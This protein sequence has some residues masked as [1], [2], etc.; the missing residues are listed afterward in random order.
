MKKHGLLIFLFILDILLIFGFTPSLRSMGVMSVYSLME[1]H[2]SVFKTADIDIQIPGGTY[3]S[4]KDW[5]PFV[6]TY[7][8]DGFSRYTGQDADLTILYN[9]GAFNHQTHCS[10]LYNED[11]PYH[12]AFYG[13]YAVQPHGNQP[14]G[15]NLDGTLAA[16]ELADIFRYDMQVLV[17]E[18]LGCDDP[19]FDYTIITT[20]LETL[21]DQSFDVIEAEISTNSP[22]HRQTQFW[23]SYLQYGSPY[24]L[25]AKKDFKKITTYGRIYARHYAQQNITLCFYVIA[26]DPQVIADTAENIIQHTKLQL[27]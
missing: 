18:S 7:N 22:L 6:M 26:P 20:S 1:S 23:M 12:G 14:F 2:D 3:T 8:A 19:M 5:Y 24:L 27:H 21:L 11:S 25:D 9:F 4:E 15:Y 13:A 17:L 16:E 10:E